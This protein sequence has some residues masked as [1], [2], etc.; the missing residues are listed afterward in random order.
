MKKSGK[1]RLA[2]KGKPVGR[3]P[4]IKVRLVDADGDVFEYGSVREAAKALGYT[5][6]YLRALEWNGEKL[7][8]CSVEF[9]R[10]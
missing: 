3:A 10:G 8:G 2:P 4:W 9:V 5:E 1:P 6:G 7:R